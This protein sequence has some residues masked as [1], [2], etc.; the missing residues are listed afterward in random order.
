MI[1]LKNNTM[2]LDLFKRILKEIKNG[3]ELGSIRYSEYQL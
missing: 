3:N 2:N 1:D